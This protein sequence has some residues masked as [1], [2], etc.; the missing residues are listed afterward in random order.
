MFAFLDWS[1]LA[2]FS[3]AVGLTVLIVQLLKLP[4]DKVWK[5]PTRYLVFSVCF[6]IM[7]VAQYFIGDGLT[8]K[9]IV[10]SV[11][12]AIVGTLAAMALYEQVIEMPER[13]KIYAT[14]QYM[15]TGN[16]GAEGGSESRDREPETPS[17]DDEEDEGE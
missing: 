5:I 14:Y 13:E 15:L 7:L 3:G 12:N 1:L 9:I 6:A 4:L 11:F 2:T 16:T 8:L 17:Q 10:M